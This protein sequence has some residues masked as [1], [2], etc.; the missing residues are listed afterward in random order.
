MSI[1][2][3]N[4]TVGIYEMMIQY[5]T[6]G[7][8]LVNQ[9][10][11]IIQANEFVANLFGY[12]LK[13]LLGLSIEQLLPTA[14][15]TTHEQHRANYLQQPTARAMGKGLNLQ[16][17]RKDG[18][19]FPVE[20]SLGHL[21]IKGGLHVVAYINDI[22]ERQQME[23]VLADYQSRLLKYTEELELRVIQRTEDL[24]KALEQEK[25]L[26]ELKSRFVSMASHEFRT[27]LSSMLSS[28]ELLAHYFQNGNR[29]KGQKNIDRIKNSVHHLT[30]ILNDFLNLEKLEARAIKVQIVPTP[31]KE[32]VTEILEE[33]S[34]L[35]KNGQGI[36]VAQQTEDILYLDSYLVK[37]ILLNL[38]SNASKY[39]SADAIIQLELT[40]VADIL[41]L[42]VLDKGI[43][44][45]KA[46][47]VNL[48][49]RFYRASNAE[50]IQGTGLG[51]T[52]VKQYV[53]LM[54]GSIS[55]ES[56]EG[57]G[58]RFMVELPLG[59]QS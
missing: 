27:P 21:R 13:E 1:N 50:N 6:I 24:E 32:W 36:E 57:E 26:G 45:P 35:L 49:T 9:K 39:S 23:T 34:P 14:Q 3:I 11:T 8:L 7:I 10:G 18:R 2:N 31:I 55:F 17:L 56:E 22:T 28:A 15:R 16:A 54:K 38:L 19:T 20:I 25:Q 40:Q 44:I 29:A 5:A 52:I 30:N 51:L 53:A 58:S 37:N 48:F 33:L 4:K 43:G 46:E 41:Q 42:A 59:K 12:S 47:Q